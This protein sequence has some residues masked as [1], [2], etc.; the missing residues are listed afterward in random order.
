M[1]MCYHKTP[2]VAV[3]GAEVGKNTRKKCDMSER[4]ATQH[5]KCRLQAQCCDSRNKKVVSFIATSA[6]AF[7]AEISDMDHNLFL[8]RQHKK[9]REIFPY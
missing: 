8:E 7:L 6:E 3:T 5:G 2:S 9:E 4:A 1:K